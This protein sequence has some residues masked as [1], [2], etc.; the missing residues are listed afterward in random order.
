MS[1][2]LSWIFHVDSV[3]MTADVVAGKTSLGGSESA[4]LGLARALRR[5]GHTVF[6]AA[7][8]LAADVP[9]V[10]AHGVRWLASEDLP[11]AQKLIDPDVFVALRQPGI[12][13]INVQAR[14]R[15]LWNQDMLIGDEGKNWTMAHSWAF[16]EVAYVSEYHR[17]QWEGV[18]PELKPLGW[19]TKNGF[20]AALVPTDVAK[21]PNRII[22]ISRPE[23][24]MTPLLAMWPELK[25]RVPEAELHVCRYQSM[26]DGE[27]SNVKAMVESYDRQIAAVNAEVG[28]IVQLGQLAKPELY[29]AIASASVMWYPG[30]V[31]FA[32]TS[33]IAAIEAQACG[34]PIVCSYKGALP[35]TAPEAHFVH[36]DAMSREYQAQSISAVKGYLLDGAANGSIY[37]KVA[38]AGLKHVQSYTYDAIAEQWET[39]LWEQFEARSAN[40][41]G[42]IDALVHEDDYCAALPLMTDQAQIAD[43]IRVI[44]GEEQGAEQ[45]G[46]FALDPEVEMTTGKQ[47]RHLAVVEAFAGK[48][49]ILDLAC[50]N[51]AFGILLAEADPDRHVTGIDYSAQNIEAAKIAAERHA[52][53]DRTDFRHAVVCDLETGM[54]NR[55]ALDNM[56]SP[57]GLFLGEFLEHVAGAPRLLNELADALGPGV[58]VV[59]T[60]PSGPFSEMLPVDMPKQRGHVHHYR[61]YDLDVMFGEQD[62]FT[63][64]YLDCGYSPRG[65]ALGHWIVR[66]VTNPEKPIH[67]RPL[68]HWAKTTRPKQTLSVGILAH[69][70]THDLNKCLA[71]VWP[72]ADEI[73]IADTGSDD[74][75][76]LEHIAARWRAQIIDCPPV[77][78]LWGGF[79]EAR[80]LTLDRAT[81]DWFLWIDADETL[82]G[83]GGISKY[84]ESGAFRGY[85]IFQNHLM[86]DCPKH[87]DTPVRLFRKGPDIEFYGCV[88]E[89][90]QQGDCNGDI[91]PALQLF[92]VQIAHVGYLT[93]QVRRGKSINRNLPLLLRDQQVFPD[94]KLG[95]VL[96]IRDLITQ[97]NW[98][99]EAN[100]G[101][102]DAQVWQMYRKAIDLFE[103]NFMDP[104]NKY[105]AIARP[106]YEAA[107]SKVRGA[108]E[109]EIALGGAVGGLKGRHAKPQTFW[110]RT[111]EHIQPLLDYH[112]RQ[113]M[114]VYEPQ[115]VD[116]EPWVEEAVAV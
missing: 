45:Y 58:S 65:K 12:F 57:D 2:R 42:V 72:I 78:A 49:R 28:G 101:Q 46:K 50:G 37:R 5:R 84:L 105:H 24:A 1:R 29:R 59:I 48:T 11:T 20:D 54:L 70:A 60:V 68:S 23:R 106:F 99:A 35:E 114:K 52:V 26:Y 81:G 41:R 10:D 96:V 97:G 83:N 56:L 39:H 110:V 77:Q 38:E 73:V 47:A 100:G 71:S 9:E 34:T 17:K 89:Q 67:A 95:T 85:A 18:V 93:E 64:D 66:Y 25:R 51:G 16:D 8:R 113:A 103:S 92:D 4:C 32:E 43:A 14:Y 107:V 21:V 61:P 98:R 53:G 13:R 109:I 111:P 115:A 108:M 112:N 31:D 36:G 19:V 102:P 74:R 3:P 22:H 116:V 44:R 88:H 63:V 7:T 15:M 69:N 55:S 76:E 87:A 82:V 33:C 91:Y 94:R 80:N 62:A 79:S 75:T 86:L 30:V 90:P 104:A 6:V 27:G 40:T